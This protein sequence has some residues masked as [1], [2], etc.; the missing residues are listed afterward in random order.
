MRS[1]F[2]IQSIGMMLL[3]VSLL[4]CSG[5]KNIVPVESG[6]ELLGDRKVD[7]IRDKDVLEVNSPSTFTAIKLRV[8]DQDVRIS[9]MK[10]VFINGDKLE[11]NIDQVIPREQYSK[12]IE[13]GSEGRR[14]KSIEFKYRTTGSLLKGRA[15]VLVFGQKSYW[16]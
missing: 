9:D 16:Q 7:F 15:D 10:I 2:Y 11:P 5:T 1:K 8:T 14:L 12:V 13:L 3:M 4:A 6:W